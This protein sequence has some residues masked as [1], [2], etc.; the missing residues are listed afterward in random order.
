M[1]LEQLFLKYLVERMN[2]LK[3]QLRT[4]AKESK[5]TISLLTKKKDSIISM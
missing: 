5:T 4:L 2:K 3:M 1:I